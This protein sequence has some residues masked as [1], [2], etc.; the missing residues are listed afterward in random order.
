[1]DQNPVEAETCLQ[2]INDCIKGEY[3]EEHENTPHEI[4]ANDLDAND[5]PLSWQKWSNDLYTKSNDLASKSENGSTMNAF[6]NP[7]AAKKIKDLMQILPLWTGV[8]RPHF[9]YGTKVTTSSV[10]ESC[11]ATYKSQLSKGNIPMRVDKFITQH[12]NYIDGRMHIDF[13]ENDCSSKHPYDDISSDRNETDAHKTDSSMEVSLLNSTTFGYKESFHVNDSKII[14]DDS[15][16]CDTTDASTS[17]AMSESKSI[18]ESNETICS[19][20]FEE[21]CMGLTKKNAKKFSS[22]KRHTYLE[23]CPEWDSVDSKDTVFIPII[24]N[25]SLCNPI[26]IQNKT[27]M[28]RNTCLFDALLH[29]TAYIISTHHDYK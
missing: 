21:D 20:N 29:I 18:N 24:K 15:Y 23:K 26:K 17:V 4:F 6:Y 13:A 7:E 14:S 28:I 22:V 16:I 11:F 1:M 19:L 25:G 27:I 8:M 5:I 3:I 9:K 10:V 12:F 2:N